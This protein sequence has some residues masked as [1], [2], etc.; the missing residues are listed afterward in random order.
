MKMQG[1]LDKFKSKAPKKG[2][3]VGKICLT[4]RSAGCDFASDFRFFMDC[5]VTNYKKQVFFPSDHF[6]SLFGMKPVGHFIVSDQWYNCVVDQRSKITW[7]H[8]HLHLHAKPSG[9]ALSRKAQKQTDTD[10]WSTGPGP[11]RNTHA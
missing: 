2:Q 6:E 7:T 3:E 4:A 1:L 9:Q 8:W 11:E 10:R 5:P